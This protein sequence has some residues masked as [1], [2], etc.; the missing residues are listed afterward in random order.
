VSYQRIQLRRDTAARWAAAN[1]VLAQGEPGYETDTG[2]QKIGNGIDPWVSLDYCLEQGPIGPVG[3][4]GVPGPQ[5]ERGGIGDR[6]PQGPIGASGPANSL[7]I[8]TVASG[9]SASAAITGLAPSQV[10]SLVLPKGDRGEVGPAGPVGPQG[11]QGD[12]AGV[13]IRGKVTQWPPSND[14]NVGDIYIVPS[15]LPSYVP[16]GFAA[17]DAA[18]WDG[19]AWVNAGP[20]QGPKGDK[21]DK[22]DSGT[23]GAVGGVGPTGPSGPA[24]SL[25]VG[26]VTEGMAGTAPVVTI[27]GAAPSQTISFVLPAAPVNSLSIGSVTQGSTA[28]AWIEGVPPNQILNLI[29]PNPAIFHSTSFFLN[30]SNTSVIEG[31]TARFTASANSTEWPIV[32]SWQSSADGSNWT[33]IAGSGS[34]ALAFT[35][36]TSQDQLLYR[37]SAATPS[38]GRTYSQIAKLTVTPLPGL[39]EGAQRFKWGF[40]NDMAALGGQ[41]DYFIGNDLWCSNNRLFTRGW[42]STNGINWTRMIGGPATNASGQAVNSVR[43][44]GSAW[45]MAVET[46]GS[47]LSVAPE[48][49]FASSNGVNWQYLQQMPGDA[50]NNF[51]RIGKSAFYGSLLRWIY[52]YTNG[53]A[54]PYGVSTTTDGISETP[55]GHSQS[56]FT[57]SDTSNDIS[58]YTQ[59]PNNV[60]Q[61]TSGIGG[62]S[63][64]YDTLYGVATGMVGGQSR[65]VAMSASK[66]WL[67][68]QGQAVQGVSAS[69]LARP[70][71]YDMN[72]P[73][74]ANG[75]W[76]GTHV[77]EPG[78]YFTSQD[79][80]NWNTHT[81]QL[82]GIDMTQYRLGRAY[83]LNGR[84][85]IAV[86][87]KFN[88]QLEG[89]IYSD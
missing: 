10:L 20:I 60:N 8:G 23:D 38:I 30:P 40:R 17:G 55:G 33:D 32:Y 75:W 58:C 52:S 37:C 25:F 22:G 46:D 24:N 72:P 34:D 14:P 27:T 1:P 62:V 29:L 51:G 77:N 48:D 63:G 43:W 35:T 45:M 78:V 57:Q 68:P 76:L 18:L 82:T 73:C 21:G 59:S 5:G 80:V 49:R 84:F 19:D 7:S 74:Y 81:V 31:E 70:V 39:A 69:S 11:P 16:E 47:S 64:I 4:Q 50:P 13:V 12:A 67:V 85:V 26:S 2:R 28:S 36:N 88:G 15:P 61:I 41:Y 9:P 87:G 79:L 54:S 3:P 53:L 66:W 44:A 89:V 83:V 56:Y 65:H 6:G 86:M 71:G 42:T